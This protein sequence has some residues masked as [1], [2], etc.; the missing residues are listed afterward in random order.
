LVPLREFFGLLSSP[1]SEFG[2][3]FCCVWVIAVLSVWD[4]IF[5]FVQY[6]SEL[7][8]NFFGWVQRLRNVPFLELGL[9][10]AALDCAGIVQFCTKGCG[11]LGSIFGL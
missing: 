3:I 6:V 10:W 9:G 11:L 4:P 1:F 7:C 2:L 5:V 8:N